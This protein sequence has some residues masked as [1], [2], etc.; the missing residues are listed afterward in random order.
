MTSPDTSRTD[1]PL[2]AQITRA[3]VGV[4][5]D[6]T[7][8]GPTKARTFLNENTVHVLLDDTMT[9]AERQLAVDGEEEFV[10]DIRRKF[11]KTMRDDLVAAV[12]EL[13]GRKGDRLHERQHDRARHGARVV[14]ARVERGLFAVLRP[15]LRAATLVRQGPRATSVRGK[16]RA[17]R[18]G[19]NVA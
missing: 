5:R 10:L 18:T 11:Q 3:V 6:Y 2:A 19:W 8:R 14:R 7:R 12:E 4:F 1:G 15:R 13:R 17:T 9:T 16:S